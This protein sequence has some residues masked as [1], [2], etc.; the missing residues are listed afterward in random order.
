MTTFL[1]ETSGA[2]T[3]DLVVMSAGLVGL[4]LAVSVAASSGMETLAGGVDTSLRSVVLRPDFNDSPCP[5]DWSDMHGRNTGLGAPAML[6]WYDEIDAVVDNIDVRNTLIT[7]ARHP[8]DFRYR[9]ARAMAE[10]QIHYC[11]AQERAIPL[12]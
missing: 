11:L 3:I 7:Y 9:E 6:E 2:V 5:E 1:N 10:V 12:P 8:Y 4:G